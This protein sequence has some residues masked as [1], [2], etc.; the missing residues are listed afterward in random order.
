MNTVAVIGLG[1][2]ARRHRQNLK[3]LFPKASIVAMSASGRSVNEPIDFADLVL[4][5]MSE[6]IESSPELV[7]IASPSPFHEAHASALIKKNI[8]V[9][10][11]KP[12]ASEPESA[13][14]ILELIKQ[15]SSHVEIGYCL[16]HL[17]SA[18]IIKQLISK[19]FIGEIYNCSATVGQYLP[20]WRPNKHYT[21]CVSAQESLGG[22]ALLE[23][24]HELDYLH[25]LLGPLKLNYAQ[26]RSTKE[27]ELE[28]EEIADLVLT[29]QKGAVC[30][31]HMDF[32]QKQA[33]RECTFIGSKGRLH[34]NL[35]TNTV[36]H[37]N[38]EGTE[39]VYSQPEWDKNQMY[40]NMV[41]AF[42]CRIQGEECSH[43]TLEDAYKTIALIAKIKQKAE[44]GIKL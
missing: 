21:T 35:I 29:S 16:R 42:I 33:Q 44:W 43:S 14:R 15:Y 34:W 12:L 3:L 18:V 30:Y 39:I 8:P 28:V 20:D 7:I 6:L 37:H 25:W 36:T 5:D 22:G 4:S 9:L 27:L 40:L 2:I 24:S 10:I 17:S 38:D 13:Q 32:I 1:N 11:E 31:I 19:N 23:L 41:T 26:L